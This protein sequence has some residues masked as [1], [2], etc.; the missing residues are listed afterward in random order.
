MAAGQWSAIGD[1]GGLWSP[2]ALES[3]FPDEQPAAAQLGFFGGSLAQLAPPPPLCAIALLGYPQDNFDV[4]NEQ[5]LA[6][7]AAQ[8]AQKKE[9]QEKQ[10][11]LLHPKGMSTLPSHTGSGS[12][13]TGPTGILQ[14]LQGSST[15]LDSINTG[16]AGVLQVL[17]G[18][19]TTLDS[20]NTGSAGF[21]EAL[22]GS[23]ITLDKPADDGYNWRKY[24]QKAVK[25]GKCP[26]SYY[27]C[28]L[29]CPVRKNVEHSADGRIIKIVYRGQHCH[30]PPSKRFKDCGDLLNELDELNDAEEP[31][32]RSLLGCQGYYGKPKPITPN[33]TMVDGL[34]PT[35]EEGDEQLS[36]LSDIRE[37]DGEIRT[38]D[39]DVGDADA[40]ERNAPGQ[41][42][43]VSTTSDVDLLDDGYRWRKY[44]QKVVRGNPHPRSYYKCTYQGCDVKKH[45]ERS[46]QEPHAVITTYEGKHTHDVP[47]SRNRSQATGSHHCKEQ[48]YSEQ[49]AASFCS[50]SEKRKYGTVILNDLAF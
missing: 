36:S 25:G 10:A 39:G 46:S 13:N 2:Q 6:Q 20:I 41:K 30:E 11:A 4:F 21:L 19:S 27:K 24:G 45:V 47:E 37:D 44:G 5:D 38:V 12:M 32:T 7:V 16:S 22:Q 3:L 49:P 50:S 31:S 42:I 35:K 8:V 43:I 40:N 23:S 28:T 9:L 48:T 29:N 14:V 26:R 34:L 33:G 18:S 15:T 1:G 17:Q